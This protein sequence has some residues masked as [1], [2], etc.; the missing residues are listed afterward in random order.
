MMGVII[1]VAVLA[2][3]SLAVISNQARFTQHQV[4][5]TR[6]FYAAQA[7]MVY[8]LEQ[9][10]TDSWVPG[11]YTLCDSAPCNVIDV[12]IPYLVSINIGASGSGI[13]GTSKI[14]VF[15]DYKP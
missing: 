2:V 1:L 10:R 12:D 14:D 4:S 11:V 3:I 9:L 8:A 13:N 5:R 7:G 15:V 6:A